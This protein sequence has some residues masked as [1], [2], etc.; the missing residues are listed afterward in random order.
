[1]IL[2]FNRETETW[3]ISQ[4]FLEHNH[5]LQLPEACHLLPSQRMISEVQAFEIEIA[6]DSGI[7]P[8]LAHEFA[9]RRV[10]GTSN[11]SYTP[12][13]HRNHLRTKRQRDLK[14]GEAGSMLKYFQ[15][16]AAENPL[17]KHDFQLDCEEKI[18][19]IFWADAKMIIDYAHFGDVITFDTTFGTNKEHRPFGVFVGFNHFRETVIFGASLLYDETFDSF[20]WLFEAFLSVH[21]EKQPR[22]I[23]TDQDSAWL[24][25]EGL[26]MRNSQSLKKNTK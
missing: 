12:R 25:L 11:L 10:G 17:F 14:Y 16:K 7:A 26:L 8:K 9:S 15:D 1:M 18:T 4:I 23:F 6:D 22:T 3:A 24:K 21:N 2:S 5:I 13:D 20:K 19:N